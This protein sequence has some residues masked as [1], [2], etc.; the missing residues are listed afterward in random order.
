MIARDNGRGIIQTPGIHT[1]A[2][3]FLFCSIVLHCFLLDQKPVGNSPPLL[4]RGGAAKERRIKAANS[5]SIAAIAGSL[6]E[7]RE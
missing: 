4:R 6:P 3:T 1:V 2:R 5:I 7:Q